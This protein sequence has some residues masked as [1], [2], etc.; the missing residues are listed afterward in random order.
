MAGGIVVATVF[1]SSCDAGYVSLP[2]RRSLFHTA[3]VE[4]FRG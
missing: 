1:F 3:E 4:S 2:R